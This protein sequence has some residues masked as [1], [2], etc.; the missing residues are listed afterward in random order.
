MEETHQWGGDGEWRG[1]R[2][3][4]REHRSRA[5]EGGFIELTLEWTAPAT[6][7]PSKAMATTTR[8]T[9]VLQGAYY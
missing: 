3:G 6:R 2:S 7:L 9:E 4:A 5:R 8:T 1:H